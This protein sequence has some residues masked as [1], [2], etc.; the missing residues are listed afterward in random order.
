[1]P[2][3]FNLRFGFVSLHVCAGR[4]S[5]IHPQPPLLHHD[6]YNHSSDLALSSEDV[7]LWGDTNHVRELATSTTS[8]SIWSSSAKLVKSAR[9]PAEILLGIIRFQPS[10]SIISLCLTVRPLH[11]TLLN[12]DRHFNAK[13]EIL[14][15]WLTTAQWLCAIDSVAKSH[16]QCEAVLLTDSILHKRSTLEELCG[17]NWTRPHHHWRDWSPDTYPRTG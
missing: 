8:K 5:I 3:M 2:T 13:S 9:S 14:W 16:S 11:E 12:R 15:T 6:Y 17:R 10:K 4:W 1:M 7:Y